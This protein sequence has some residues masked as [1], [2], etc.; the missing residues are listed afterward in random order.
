MG[1]LGNYTFLYSAL[2]ACAGSLMQVD[3]N[4]VSK[5]LILLCDG[6]DSGG[7]KSEDDCRELLARYGQDL[8]LVIIAV[9]SDVTSGS[10]LQSFADKVEKSGSVGSYITATN[11]DDDTAI[12]SAFAQVEE[13]LMLSGGGQTEAG[14]N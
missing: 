11:E 8:N 3:S 10:V 2:G 5:W 1:R 9:G 4:D 6:D 7:G 14:G 12:R 13:S